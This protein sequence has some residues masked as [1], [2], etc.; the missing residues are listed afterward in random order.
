MA[1]TQPDLDP[2]RRARERK[3]KERLISA[4][5]LG[6]VLVLTLG[7]AL[8]FSSINREQRTGPDTSTIVSTTTG[9]SSWTGGYAPRGLAEPDPTR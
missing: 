9:Q 7:I 1:E 5:I 6:A 2:Y 8:A 3:N 4:T